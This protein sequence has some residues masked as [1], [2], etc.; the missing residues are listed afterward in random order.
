M[1]V[2]GVGLVRS[3]DLRYM[4]SNMYEGEAL[5]SLPPLTVT[6]TWTVTW[7]I[8]LNRTD[9]DR[10]RPLTTHEARIPRTAGVQ[11]SV[12]SIPVFNS[13]K[14]QLCFKLYTHLSAEAELGHVTGRGTCMP[15]PQG[16][17]YRFGY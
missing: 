1:D 6:V 14:Y 5:P 7:A 10:V 3:L 4:S 11:L 8:T 15:P 13:K 16:E 9:S 17:P 12:S 2:W